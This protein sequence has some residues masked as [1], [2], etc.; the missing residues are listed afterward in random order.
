MN[1]IKTIARIGGALYLVNITLGFFA[2]G[3]VPGVIEVSGNPA[4]TAHNIIA[5][6]AFYRHGCRKY[7]Y[8]TISSKP[9][10]F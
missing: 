2:I 5:H 6:E 1:S 4:A 3:Y 7:F 10:A 8:G 9:I